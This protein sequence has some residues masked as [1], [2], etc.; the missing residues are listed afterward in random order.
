[1][2]LMTYSPET[3]PATMRVRRPGMGKRR[4]LIKKRHT[5][6]QIVRLLRVAEAQM[7]T[8]ASSTEAARKLG[9]ARQPSITGGTSMEG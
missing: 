6:E 7:A 8:G 1:M 9:S 4:I 3:D 5:P 2:E